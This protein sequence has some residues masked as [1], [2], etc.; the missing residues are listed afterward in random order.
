MKRQG[1][2]DHKVL[3][4]Y[5]SDAP[6]NIDDVLEFLQDINSHPD[7]KTLFFKLLKDAGGVRNQKSQRQFDKVTLKE[8][9]GLLMNLKIACKA[10]LDNLKQQHTSES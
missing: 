5:L 2:D 9:E 8:L 6:G 7:R 1:L 3:I 10:I 4:S